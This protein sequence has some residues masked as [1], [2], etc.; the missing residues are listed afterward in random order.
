MVSMVEE[1]L[2]TR[3]N[4]KPLPSPLPLHR[5]VQL[6]EREFQQLHC[7]APYPM[8]LVHDI[9]YLGKSL[10]FLGSAYLYEAKNE[11]HN[12]CCI[13]LYFQVSKASACAK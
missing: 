7:C 4:A 9:L 8:Y 1:T 2:R 12:C 11:V 6:P 5:Q 3:A 10:S 13:D